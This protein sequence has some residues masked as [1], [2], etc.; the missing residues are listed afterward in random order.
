M[1]ISRHKFPKCALI[2][3]RPRIQA[4]NKL[5]IR[6][7]NVSIMRSISKMTSDPNLFVAKARGTKAFV[8]IKSSSKTRPSASYKLSSQVRSI[9][10]TELRVPS[11]GGC[12]DDASIQSTNP[13]RRFKRRGSKSA[14]MFKAFSTENIIIPETLFQCETLPEQEN[15]N[16]IFI[17]SMVGLQNRLAK[18][19]ASSCSSELEELTSSFSSVTETSDEFDCPSYE[20]WSMKLL[21]LYLQ[22]TANLQSY[23][24]VHTMCWLLYWRKFHIHPV[25]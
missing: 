6:P 18:F 5:L 16:Q 2:L 3:N 21:R 13:H 1:V 11:N 14:S 12:G 8:P 20:A 9:L 4:S 23:Y 10:S 22:G 7:I 24:H 15:T 19:S 17:Q 25:S